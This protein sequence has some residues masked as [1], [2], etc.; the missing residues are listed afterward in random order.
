[1]KSIPINTGNLDLSAIGNIQ[2]TPKELK[3][4][5]KR[6]P[7]ELKT[8]PENDEGMDI[9][10]IKNYLKGH[11]SSASSIL[12][13]PPKNTSKTSIKKAKNTPQKLEDAKNTL[14]KM[15]DHKNTLQKRVVPKKATKTDSIH[16]TPQKPVYDLKIDVKS[17]NRQETIAR[18]LKYQESK[19]FK[20]LLKKTIKNQWTYEM[21]SKKNETQLNSIINR[22]RV[23]I[24]NQSMNS[25]YDSVITN[26]SLVVEKGLHNVYN[27][28]G[29]TDDLTSN[30][31]FWILFEKYKIESNLPT[32][33]ISFQLMQC[34][35]GTA[36]ISHQKNLVDKVPDGPILKSTMKA[37]DKEVMK[38]LFL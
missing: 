28:D 35:V 34:I 37:P 5:P 14:Q 17:K 38:D 32:I 10:E 23:V 6:N 30:E 24:E 3:P 22:I 29:F 36:V 16:F 13:K 9:N 26:S 25:F 20:D 7:K 19:Y 12:S 2:Q 11:H 4:I 27:I 31:H 8:I 21:L 15:E 1:M 18:I 33:P